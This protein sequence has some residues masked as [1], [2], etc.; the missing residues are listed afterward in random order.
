MKP[1]EIWKALTRPNTVQKAHAVV[2]HYQGKAELSREDLQAYLKDI[3]DAIKH[4]INP[5]NP[6]AVIRHVKQIYIRNR[7]LL[8]RH[9]ICWG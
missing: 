6:D 8:R 9:N 5:A 2:L 7:A 1:Q 4:Q 3:D